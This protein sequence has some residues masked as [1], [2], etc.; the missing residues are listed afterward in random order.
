MS[1]PKL[2]R[3]EIP[4]ILLDKGFRVRWVA[5]PDDK[6]TLLTAKLVEEVREFLKDENIEELADITEVVRELAI[7]LGSGPA[8][9]EITRQDKREK[10][11]GFSNSVVL[12]EYEPCGS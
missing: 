4:Y 9:L 1:E 8:E 3:D 10:R 6:K 11:G 2:V 7:A 5:K 12:L